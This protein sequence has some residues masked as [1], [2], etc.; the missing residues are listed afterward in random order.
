MGCIPVRLLF[1]IP[2]PFTASL[3]FD[4]RSRARNSEY[5]YL[6]ILGIDAHLLGRRPSHGQNINE[7][8]FG[9]GP[10]ENAVISGGIEFPLFVRNA[11]DIRASYQ[12]V[13]KGNYTATRL[14]PIAWGRLSEKVRPFPFLAQVI[15]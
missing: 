9:F 13:Y 8:A 11:A 14:H 5:E 2:T 3:I 1:F 7:A 6:A 4:G 12:Y 15:F 10:A